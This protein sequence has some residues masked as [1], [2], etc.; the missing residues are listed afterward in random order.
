MNSKTHLYRSVTKTLP[1]CNIKVIFQSKNWLS[2]LFK[3]KDSITLYLR[4][5]FIYKLQFSNCII[6]NYGETEGHPKVRAS[7]Y[8]SKSALNREWANNNKK[9]VA[10]D[11]YLLSGYMCSFDGLT[12][13]NYCSQKLKRLITLACTVFKV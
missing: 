9:S 5:H 4:S 11:H 12:V 6:I 8:I 1:Q 7:E 3:F 10:K 2:S 13:L